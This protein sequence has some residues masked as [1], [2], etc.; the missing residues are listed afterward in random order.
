MQPDFFAINC[1][2]ITVFSWFTDFKF[3]T[4]QCA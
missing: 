2:E 3:S 1:V 4:I